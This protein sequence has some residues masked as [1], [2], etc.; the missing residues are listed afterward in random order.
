MEERCSLRQCLP[1]ARFSPPLSLSPSFLLLARR[2]HLAELDKRGP[3]GVAIV[4]SAATNLAWQSRI[5]ERAANSQAAPLRLVETIR[6]FSLSQPSDHHHH[7][8]L[9]QRNSGSRPKESM[10]A[11]CNN[12]IHQPR[13]FR[14]RPLCSERRRRRRRR[15]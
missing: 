13:G 14:R 7:H 6:L 10:C 3:H 4:S 15:R 5:S 2:W 8:L 11:K 1:A 12:I 9:R